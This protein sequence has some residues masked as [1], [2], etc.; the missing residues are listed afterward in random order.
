MNKDNSN[1]YDIHDELVNLVTR[2][3]PVIEAL[4]ALIGQADDAVATRL[5]HS[6][7]HIDAKIEEMTAVTQKLDDSAISASEALS[8]YQNLVLEQLQAAVTT[9][10]DTE[11]PSRY[12]DKI[13]DIITNMKQ[14]ID[15]AVQAVI[16]AKNDSI[17]AKVNAM[18]A[19][20]D[21][22]GVSADSLALFTS[23]YQAGHEQIIK[24]IEAFE[25]ATKKRIGEVKEDADKDLGKIYKSIESMSI[26]RIAAVAAACTAAV[27]I[28]LMALVFWYV[29]SFD[30][31]AEMRQQQAELQRGIDELETGWKQAF[32]NAQSAQFILA[33]DVNKDQPDVISWCVRADSKSFLRDEKGF[34]YYKI[35]GSTRAKPT[36]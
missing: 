26:K 21:K 5:D 19:V 10:T 35:S 12:D 1:E 22:L 20:A 17:E 6:L 28:S 23:Q 34:V 9:F 3:K 25:N 15:T 4:R 29:P 33:C 18:Q 24:D 2:L 16:T 31:I 27:V 30:K 13:A 32:N 36:E 7:S 8:Q 14:Q 11:M